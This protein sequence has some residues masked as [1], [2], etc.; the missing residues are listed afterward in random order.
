VRNHFPQKNLN[1][2]NFI[3][4][5]GSIV[6]NYLKIIILKLLLL[7][8]LFPLHSL[9]DETF[10]YRLG[11]GDKLAIKVFNQADL[12]GEYTVDGDGK[13]SM[14]LIGTVKLDNMTLQE[15]E[16]HLKKK[17]SPD[18]LLNPRITIQV[19]NY[20]PFYIMGEVKSTG[21]YPFVS[22]M[23]YL[24]SVAIAGGFTYRAKEAYVFVVH[25]NDLDKKEVQENI[26]NYV[27]PGDIIRVDERLF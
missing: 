6:V 12:T 11:S 16:E 19:L 25:A 22:G 24:T 15:L 13:I 9:A 26:G 20:R 14:P 21:S 17:L 27:R 8:C 18:F 1:S 3:S 7:G 23:S 10:S 5:I 2:K 4:N